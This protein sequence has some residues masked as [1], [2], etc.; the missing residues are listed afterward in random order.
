MTT[1]NQT[2]KQKMQGHDAVLIR[3]ESVA[4]KN[5]ENITSMKNQMETQ[6]NDIICHT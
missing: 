5:A 6:M 3:L 2:M 1:R 4:T